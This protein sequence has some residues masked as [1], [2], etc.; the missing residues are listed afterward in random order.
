MKAYLDFQ[1]FFFAESDNYLHLWTFS[2]PGAILDS[3][4][5]PKHEFRVI[6][7]IF[8]Q[9]RIVTSIC[10]KIPLSAAI[11]DSKWPPRHEFGVILLYIYYVIYIYT[12]YT[13]YFQEFSSRIGPWP[14]LVNIFTFG[15]HLGFKMNE[16][17]SHSKC[18]FSLNSSWIMDMDDFAWW[19]MRHKTSLFDSQNEHQ[20]VLLW[21]C[22]SGYFLHQMSVAP[23]TMTR[24]N[25]DGVGGAGAGEGIL[26]NFSVEGR[27]GWEFWGWEG[28]GLR[29]IRCVC[30]GGGGVW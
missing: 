15:S 11:L 27:A 30:L 28:E 25:Q 29:N 1:D 7:R 12:I 8:M 6:F 20:E 14:P 13:I 5:L 17:L 10:E 4:W 9:H 19:R 24:V 16:W 3:K 2:L 26:G 21:H 18:F 22:H 23:E